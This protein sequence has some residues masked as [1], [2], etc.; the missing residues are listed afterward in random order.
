[1]STV[2]AT[3]LKHASSAS[4]NIVLDSSGNATFAGTPVPNSS[5]LRNRIINGDMRIDQRNAGAAIASLGSGST[6]TVDRFYYYGSQSGKFSFQQNQ[7]SVTPPAGFSNYAGF[8]S[9]SAFSAAASDVFVF[10]SA[11]TGVNG[12][13]SAQNL[14][15]YILGGSGGATFPA[16]N[17][18]GIAT[19]TFLKA[20]T[21]TVGAGLTVTGAIT[22]NGGASITGGETTL[23][24][25]TVSD[26]TAGRVVL[27]G[28]SG[29][30][31]DSSNLTFGANGL[32][33]TGGA[34]V[35]AASTFGSNLSVG[36]N[37]IVSGDLTVNGT[38]TQINT[39]QTTIEDTLLELQI[40]DGTAPSSDTN[41][42]VG[43][44]MNYYD[45]Q[46]RKAAF[47]WDDSATRFVLAATASESTGVVTPA[48]YGGLEI[49]SL[50]LNDCAG[51]SQ[52]I[53]CSGTT[54]S[55]ENI[56]IDGGSF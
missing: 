8:T 22:G 3:N 26:L 19:A 2:S 39:I 31:E 55:L 42:D 51:A 35:S 56:T 54:R 41:K 40:V 16:I 50:Y 28:T 33:V 52:V 44:I 30:L 17:V 7:G 24:S 13:V 34:N 5:F 15:N 43:L 6:Y 32:R 1:M 11:A 12:K 47:F 14:S 21:A 20:T 29:A 38:T 49:G 36:G 27:A 10:Q 45:T 53:S 4:N 18:T 23:S 37:V 46:A 9:L 25:A 48:T